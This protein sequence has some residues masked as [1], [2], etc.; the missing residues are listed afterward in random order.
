MT[1]KEAVEILRHADTDSEVDADDYLKAF[2]MAVSALESESNREDFWKEL[3]KLKERYEKN[4]RN[5]HKADVVS[6][7]AYMRMFY[8]DFLKREEHPIYPGHNKDDKVV[9]ISTRENDGSSTAEE[10]E[11]LKRIKEGKGL[12]P[13]GKQKT[14]NPALDVKPNKLP[15]PYSPRHTIRDL[16]KSKR[17]SS[18]KEKE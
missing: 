8:P 1:K 9:V 17:G 2:D 12:P 7:M 13:I 16:W 10:D 11:L 5:I 4:F 18:P 14:R 15:T 6:A 3:D